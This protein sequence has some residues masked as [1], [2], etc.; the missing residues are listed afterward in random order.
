MSQIGKL[1][2]PMTF[3]RNYITSQPSTANRN[4]IIYGYKFTLMLESE[5]FNFRGTL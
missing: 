4:Q 5:K 3:I 1:N 2:P